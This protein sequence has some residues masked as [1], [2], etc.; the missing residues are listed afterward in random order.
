M[1]RLH[2]VGLYAS[3]VSKNSP[4]NG[5]ATIIDDGTNFEVIDGY[6]GKSTTRLIAMLKKRKIFRPYLHISHAH[7][8]HY[9]GIRQII[10]DKAFTPKALYCYDPS[11]LA[12]VSSAVAS[13]R[14]ALKNLISEAKARH[15][16]VIYVDNGDTI[17]HGDIKIL[18]YRDKPKYNGNSDAYINNGSLCYW[19]PNISYLTTGDAGLDV[20]EKHGLHPRFI[21][22]GHHGNNCVRKTATY[23]KDHGCQYCWDNDYNTKLTDFLMT[24]REDCIGVGM[25][26]LSAHGDINA[27][28]R[29]GKATIFKDGRFYSYSCDYD[30]KTA[31]KGASP[32]VCR[33]VLRGSYG[34]SNTRTT[35]LLNLGYAPNTVQSMVTKVVTLA[36]D[37]K[38]D[39]VDYGRNKV[40]L[41]RIDAELGKGYGQLVQDYINVLCGVREKV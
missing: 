36:K 11:V 2:V 7:Y 8:D 9:Y 31:L 4:R 27:V 1:I 21:K 13:D 12:N 41:H 6:C 17:R 34:N 25:T 3:D 10:R 18:V 16:P 38:D 30:G 26:Y 19:I 15:I 39:K 24:G 14:A 32:Y 40:R 22:I 5:D 37:I 33:K 23:L 28:F 35:N 29:G 20:A